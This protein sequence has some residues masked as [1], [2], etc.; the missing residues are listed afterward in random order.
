[1]TGLFRNQQV[2]G[3]TPAG[4]SISSVAYTKGS[5]TAHPKP[6]QNSTCAARALVAVRFHVNSRAARG[7]SANRD[8]L[9]LVEPKA[10]RLPQGAPRADMLDL[11]ST[12][13]L[14]FV[15]WVIIMCLVPNKQD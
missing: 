10:N 8:Y 3:S 4:G 14:V 6:T 11:L 9:H 15:L 5:D 12:F 7:S 1:V 2:A 13:A